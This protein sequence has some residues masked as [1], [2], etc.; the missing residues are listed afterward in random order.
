MVLLICHQSATFYLNAGHKLKKQ[1]SNLRHRIFKETRKND[2]ESLSIAWL[3]LSK[4]HRSGQNFP[5]SHSLVAHE[6]QCW[7][8]L[9]IPISIWSSWLK[10]SEYR[11]STC[12]FETCSFDDP[13]LSCFALPLIRQVV[14]NQSY[15]L[16]LPTRLGWDDLGIVVSSCLRLG[17]FLSTASHTIEWFGWKSTR[18]GLKP[19]SE[20]LQHDKRSSIQTWYACFPSHR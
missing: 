5:N 18:F 12:C 8:D 10:N 20:L 1:I 3:A 11:L 9:P 14:I 15:W 19:P 17:P 13:H 7:Y 16:S 2:K 4:S 6:V